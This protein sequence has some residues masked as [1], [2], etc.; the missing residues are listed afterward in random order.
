[1]EVNFWQN[2][3]SER[4]MTNERSESGQKYKGVPSID[5]WQES[6]ALVRLW[7]EKKRRRQGFCSI[8]KDARTI[9]VILNIAL[10]MLLLLTQHSLLQLAQPTLEICQLCYAKKEW[11]KV[12]FSPVRWK[13]EGRTHNFVKISFF[14]K[15]EFAWPNVYPTCLSSFIFLKTVEE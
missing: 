14:V 12:K 1:M 11:Q 15:L 8:E 3:K 5:C 2:K 6:K 10:G 4:G 7:D 9:G 13:A